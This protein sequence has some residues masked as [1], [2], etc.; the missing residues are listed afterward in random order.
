MVR[1]FVLALL[2]VLNIHATAQTPQVPSDVAALPDEIKNLKWQTI[3]LASLTPLEHARALL[4]LNNCLDEVAA[5]TTSQADLMSSYID[6]KTLGPD[7]AN[8]PPAP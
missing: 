4:V 7:F 5:V 3:D 1:A 8:N 2:V 6:Q